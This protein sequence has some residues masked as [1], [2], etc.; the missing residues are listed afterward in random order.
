MGI[1]AITWIAVKERTRE[2]GTRRALG[3]TAA[4]IFIQVICETGTLALTGGALG[5][6]L[7]WPASR[8]IS[9]SVGLPFVFDR[10]SAALAF[11]AAATLNLTFSMAPSRRAASISP[12]EALRYE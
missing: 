2:I 10:Q 3:A 9:D 8:F 1:V 6:A 4:D 7:S 5:I 12:I 11:I